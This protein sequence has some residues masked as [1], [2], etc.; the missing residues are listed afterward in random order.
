MKETTPA[1]D[2]E[3]KELPGKTLRKI[4]SCIYLR[5]FIWS[6]LLYKSKR[7]LVQTKVHFKFFNLSKSKQ[8]TNLQKEQLQKLFL[9]C[10]RYRCNLLQ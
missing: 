10:V 9:Q 7:R 3:R 2:Q 1:I 8:L 5:V 6:S 4:K